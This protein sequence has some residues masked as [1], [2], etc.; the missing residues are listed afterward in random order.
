VNAVAVGELDGRPVIVSGGEDG[1]VRVWELAD[2]SPVGDPLTGHDGAVNAVAVGELDGR[3]V[4]VSGGRDGTLRVWELADG[5][6]I[7]DPPT[8]HDDAV[9]AV[10]VG[11][12]D[13]R[14]VIVSGGR[15][16]TL[17][18]RELA[19]RQ[20]LV[21]AV[22]SE[23]QAVALDEGGRTVVGARAGVMLLEP[24]RPWIAATSTRSPVS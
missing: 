1:T 23:V 17:R 12:L 6:S 4:I 7:G 24:V 19:E 9:N 8:G 5:S 14:P 10:A 18:V 21:I 20:E 3:P 2:G 16:G 15:D 13:G 11:E 22:G